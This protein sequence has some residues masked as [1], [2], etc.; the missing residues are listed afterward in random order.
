M[1]TI[2]AEFRSSFSSSFSD[3]KG[4]S[5]FG[6]FAGM[7]ITSLEDYALGIHGLPKSNVL[8]FTLQSP[9]EAPVEASMGDAG[10]AGESIVFIRPSGT[11]PQLKAYISTVAKDKASALETAEKIKH[12]LDEKIKS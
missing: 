7:A 6:S 5:S 4:D 8:K 3:G 2:M 10:D 9:V 12:S 11:E 1:N